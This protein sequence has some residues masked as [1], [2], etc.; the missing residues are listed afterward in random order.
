MAVGP[1][2]GAE[3][4][5]LSR[6]SRDHHVRNAIA[7][8]EATQEELDIRWEFKRKMK[9]AGK[10]VE[11]RHTADGILTAMADAG[12]TETGIVWRMFADTIAFRL[13]GWS[14]FTQG[15]SSTWTTI[16]MYLHSASDSGLNSRPNTANSAGNE[17]SLP[18]RLKCIAG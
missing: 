13:N 18:R 3:I 8:G 1:Q 9:D 6:R 16:G 17:G 5:G 10:D 15:T 4:G 7:A 12:F 14:S 11:Y 2:W